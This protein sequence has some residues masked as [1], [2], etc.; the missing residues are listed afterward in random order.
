MN[1]LGFGGAAVMAADSP[2][3]AIGNL[4]TADQREALSW[5]QVRVHMPDG[6]EYL[7]GMDMAVPHLAVTAGLR[8]CSLLFW[9]FKSIHRTSPMWHGGIC[10]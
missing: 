5:V 4:G 6:L 10:P 8:R 3:A 7:I 1:I 9:R 2:P